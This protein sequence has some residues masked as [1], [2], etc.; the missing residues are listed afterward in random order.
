MENQELIAQCAQVAQQWL[1]SPIYDEA[2]KQEVKAMLE[3]EDK[4]PLIDSFYRTLEFGTGGLRG[5]KRDL[6]EGGIRT[7]YIV[8]WKGKVAAG[9]V[10][11]H[12]GAFWDMM[13]TFAEITNQKYAPNKH[14][15]SFLP[16]LLGKKKQKEHKHLYWEF[17]EMGGRQAVRYK[18]WK[19]VRL[20]MNKD[21]NAPIELYN[22]TTDP[23]EQHNLAEQYPKIVKKIKKIMEESHSRSERFPFSWEKE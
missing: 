15:V 17:H 10:S 3:A 20:N 12:V 21:K 1:D 4:T 5:I 9:S 14:Q 16:T 7:P 22:L 23:A 18:N 19:G 13:P 8:Y 6:Y 2:T 11:N